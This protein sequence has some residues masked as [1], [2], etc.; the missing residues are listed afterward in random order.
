M[1]VYGG[2]TNEG[3]LQRVFREVSCNHTL[4]NAWREALSKPLARVRLLGQ[5]YVSIRENLGYQRVVLLSISMSCSVSTMVN[6]LSW[7]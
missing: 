3:G 5:G 2:Y 7:T 6:V 4:Y 1:W